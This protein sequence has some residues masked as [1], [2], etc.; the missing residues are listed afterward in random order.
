MGVRCFLSLHC[1]GIDNTRLARLVEWCDRYSPFVAQDAADGIVL[2]ISG[3]VHLFGGERQLLLDLQRHLQRMDIKGRAAIADSW[4]SAWALARY[5]EKQIAHGEEMSAA[6]D[7]LPIEALR[8]PVEIAL[9][10]RR[11]GLCTIEALRKIPPRSLTVRFGSTVVW[12]LNQTLN[13]AAD[14]LTPWRPA[15]AY[16]SVRISADPIFT[17]GSVEYVLCD[18][19]K[20][21]CTAL[22]KDHL[23]SRYMHLGCYRVDGTVDCCVV[24]TS[25]P[26][27]SISHL[28]R[29]FHDKLEKLWAN[30]GFEAFVLS[31]REA[32]ALSPEQLCFSEAEES[33][34]G[35]LFDELVDRL[36]TRLGFQ[37]VNRIQVRESYLPEHAVTFRSADDS[38]FANAEWPDYRVR[39]VR[40]MNPPVPIQVSI[41]IPG[42]TPVQF[43]IGR[44]PHRIIRSEGPERLVGEWWGEENTRWP[45]RDYYRVEDEKGV[46]F[47]IFCDSAEPQRWFLHG[48][49]A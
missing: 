37:N 44:Q 38:T 42:G 21:L 3:C 31:V 6:L 16:R 30:F 10:L 17:T 26:A 20:E 40:M 48:H 27:R 14:P 23:G 7:P 32:E 33:E 28:M 24:Q 35:E 11:L 15:P 25:K 13:Q 43:F 8:L 41:V 19:L 49:F 18:L 2:D 4:G 34:D 39:P 22:Q 46:R 29:L 9:A 5:S 36:G 47:W 1:A 12:R 45:V